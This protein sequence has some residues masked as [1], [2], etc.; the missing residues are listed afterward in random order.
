MSTEVGKAY[1][2]VEPSTDG[3]SDGVG[4]NLDGESSKFKGIGKKV[5]VAIA[6]GVALGTAVIGSQIGKSIDAASDLNE[7][8][9][10]VQVVFKDNAKAVEAWANTSAT[11]FGQSKQ[12]ALEAAGTY[13]NLFQAFGLGRNE[14]TKMSTSLVGLAADLASFNNTSVDDAVLALRSGLSGETEPLKKYGVAINDARLKQEALSMGLISST[15]EALEPAAKAQA[16]YALIMHDTTLA[17][18]DFER[19]SGG[20]ANQQRILGANIQNVR[21]EIG[22][23][24]LPAKLA[25]VKVLNESVIPAFSVMGGKLVDLYVGFKDLVGTKVVEWAKALAPA[26]RTLGYAFQGFWSAFNG[27]GVTSNGLV[28]E[29]EKLGVKARALFD[30]LAA[31][32]NTVV[33]IVAGFTALLAVLVAMSKINSAVVA[34]NAMF[35]AFTETGAAAFLIANPITLVIAAI[36]AL[37]VALVIAYQKSET[38]REIVD[39]IGRVIRDVALVAFE[40]MRDAFE[41]VVDFITKKAIPAVTGFWDAIVEAFTP[42]ARW[43]NENVVSTFVAMGEFIAAVVARIVDVLQIW[44]AGMKLQWQIIEPIIEEMVRIIGAAFQFIGDLFKG[45]VQAVLPIFAAAW[46]PL[47]AGIELVWAEIKAVIEIALGAI[48]GIFQIFTGILRGDFGKIWEGI[49]T[50]VETPFNAVKKFIGEAFDIIVGAFGEMPSRIANVAKGMF[51]GIKTAFVGVINFLIRSWNSLEFKIPGFDP[52]GPGSFPGFTLGVPDIPELK[53]ATGGYIRTLVGEQ[54]PEIVDLPVGAAV[55]PNG[56]MPWDMAMA[57]V[58]RVSDIYLTI[59][60]GMGTDGA[61][62]GRQVMEVLKD[63]E[64]SN[65]PLNLRIQPT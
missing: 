40:K 64:R 1:V 11:A 34:M 65:G 51:D 27:E 26:V 33:P 57:G 18:G 62:V 32:K 36:V 56:S 25:L 4:K 42:L 49:Q 47:K 3:F 54:G 31:N 9:G 60:A 8:M 20:L 17:Q 12:Q 21:A 55:Y 24:L 45:F 7:S 2:G 46:V 63:F 14:A 22:E 5:G 50:L 59:N 37:G 15:K 38:F 52:P 30:V 6:A 16:A 41:A 29:F 48:R 43:L 23:K 58:G 39:Q 35:T 10:K 28:G 53:M 61:V 13:G 44:W 19:T